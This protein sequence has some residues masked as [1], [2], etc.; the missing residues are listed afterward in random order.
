MA[1]ALRRSYLAG[2]RLLGKA[3]ASALA[4]LF[5][6]D[7][8][9]TPL[10]VDTKMQMGCATLLLRIS[11]QAV[12]HVALTTPPCAAGQQPLQELR[13]GARLAVLAF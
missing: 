5:T 9:D 4:L 1:A 12:K 8:L 3:D 7:G 6:V 13:L 10:E 2:R 11:F